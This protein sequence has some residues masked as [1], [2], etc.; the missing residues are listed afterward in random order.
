LKPSVSK[1]GFAYRY[2][3]QIFKGS[4]NFCRKFTSDPSG[5][6]SQNKIFKEKWT[7]LSSG[8]AAKVT[9]ALMSAIINVQDPFSN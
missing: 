3:A 6:V 7:S 8:S 2:K 4:Y 9:D 1:L 5:E